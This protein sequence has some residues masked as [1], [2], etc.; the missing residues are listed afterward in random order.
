MEPVQN[1]RGVRGEIPGVWLQPL[2]SDHLLWEIEFLKPEIIFN[3]TRSLFESHFGSMN[4][5][6]AD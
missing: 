4:S 5:L 3:S 6:I 1:R 2:T